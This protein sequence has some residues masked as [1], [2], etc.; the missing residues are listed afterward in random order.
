MSPHID[1]AQQ[2][3]RT[4]KVLNHTAEHLK[5]QAASLREAAQELEREAGG[6]YQAMGPY[7]DIVEK[8]VTQP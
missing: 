5:K 7:L 6:L 1:P 8:G 4:M 2:A 3:I